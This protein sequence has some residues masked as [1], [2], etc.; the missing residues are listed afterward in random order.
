MCAGGFMF[1]GRRRVGCFVAMLLAFC[2][3]ANAQQV[4]GSIFGTVTDPS[5]SAVVGARV[6]VTDVNKGTK[7][8]VST[9]VSGNYS[10]GQLVPGQYTIA[11]ESTGFGTVKSDA[12]D[13]R[14]DAAVR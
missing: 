5:G 13:V 10:K 6:I 3:A 8:E 4:F 1:R 14:V 11:I 7:F 2:A 12:M 9:D